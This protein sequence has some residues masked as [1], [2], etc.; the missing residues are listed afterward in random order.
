M[1]RLT[2]ANRASAGQLVS[3]RLHPLDICPRRT[4]HPRLILLVSDMRSEGALIRSGHREFH[5][6]DHQF[7]LRVGRRSDHDRPVA[8]LHRESDAEYDGLRPV[9]PLGTRG[10]PP[11]VSPWRYDVSFQRQSGLLKPV[12]GADLEIVGGQQISLGQP[13]GVSG[14]AAPADGDDVVAASRASFPAGG[15]GSLQVSDGQTFLLG[16]VPGRSPTRPRRGT[17]IWQAIT[18]SAALPDCTCMPVRALSR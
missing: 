3:D 13:V 11:Y 12:E 8:G 17:F 2:L 14:R 4:G 10:R 5:S 15:S 16:R 18:T 6:G 7:L 1:T 9:R